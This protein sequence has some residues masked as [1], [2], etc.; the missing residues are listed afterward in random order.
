M[1]QYQARVMSLEGQLCKW[2]DVSHTSE[3]CSELKFSE[4]H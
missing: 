4:V 3:W 1:G 2:S